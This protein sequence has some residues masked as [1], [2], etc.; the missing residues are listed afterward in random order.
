MAGEV[1][2]WRYEPG[3]PALAEVIWS[4]EALTQLEIIRAYIYI[5]NPAASDR[6][7]ARL[8]AASN[9]LDTFPERGPAADEQL[10]KLSTVRPYIIRYYVETSGRVVIADIKHNRRNG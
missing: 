9:S 5:F 3:A 8:F 6:I 1:E 2:G 7:A 10:R 4:D